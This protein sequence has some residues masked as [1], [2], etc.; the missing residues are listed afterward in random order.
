MKKYFIYLSLLSFTLAST[1]CSEDNSIE[2][3]GKEIE[4]YLAS[5]GL[6]EQAQK[7]PEGVYYVIE[8]EGTGTEFPS[9][10]STVDV[11]YVGYLLNDNVFDSSGN[12]TARFSLTSLIEGW[13][14][15]M[16][17]FKKNGKGKIFV[18]S[19][20]GYGNQIR[21]GI[22]AGSVLGFDIELVGFFD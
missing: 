19:A 13:R 21:P 5:K 2:N 20:L 16:Q 7:T 1:A 10:T 6:L 4:D 22:P 3:E 8:E 14:V 15:G 9:A 17:K 11:K 18:P 12:S